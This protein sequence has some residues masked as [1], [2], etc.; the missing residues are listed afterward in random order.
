MTNGPTR[1][2]EQFLVHI[3]VKWEFVTAI[4]TAHESDT[5]KHIN[6]LGTRGVREPD[7]TTK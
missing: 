3:S 2:I 6:W 7:A 1:L 4:V 5:V